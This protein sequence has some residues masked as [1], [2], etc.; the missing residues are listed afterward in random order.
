[1]STKQKKLPNKTESL[2][3]TLK[4]LIKETQAE[5]PKWEDRRRQALGTNRPQLGGL[6]PSRCTCLMGRVIGSGANSKR[7]TS[8]EKCPVHRVYR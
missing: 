5:A 7:L 3:E 1:M 4:R 2:K 8:R 6:R